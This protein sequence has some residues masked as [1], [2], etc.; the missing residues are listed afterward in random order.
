M[1]IEDFK[2]GEYKEGY[3]YKYFIPEF[4]NH[5]WEW[6][7]NTLSALLEKASMS[8]GELN[9]YSNLIPSVSL[10]IQLHVTKE[11]VTSSRIE[12]TQTNI[13]EALQPSDEIKE[14]ARNDW[15]E[16]KNYT[17][18][19]NYAIE[20]L[21]KIPLSSRLIKETHSILLQGVRGKNKLPG[22]FRKSQNWVGGATIKDA[23]F[24]P[25]AHELIPE[26]MSDLEK[27][28]HNDQL[29]VPDLIKIGIIHYQFET[30][31]PFLDGNGRIGRLLITLYLVGKEILRKPLLYISEFFE[32][33][34]HL[35]Y[36]NLTIARENNN[37]LQWLKYFLVGIE[38]TS[39]RTSETLSKIL[40][41][42][43]EHEKKIQKIGGRKTERA[44]RLL[45]KLFEMPY[46]KVKDVEKICS[47]TTKS[48]NLL[49]NLMTDLKILHEVTGKTRNRLFVY[50][51]YIDLFK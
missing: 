39:N 19:I 47:L 11:A 16:V 20:R 37:L 30:I 17:K 24:I 5:S 10:F 18:A 38:Q 15:Q 32:K 22:E 3:K 42:K 31:H 9:S 45:T 26:L 50:R 4:I 41:L 7:D 49:I 6:K 35:Y 29:Q 40:S 27:F 23:V 48:A 28:I 46:V 14:E 51:D 2:S 36:H 12:G 1:F 25:P 13:E 34:K 33:E 21:K 44:I 43:E 8:L